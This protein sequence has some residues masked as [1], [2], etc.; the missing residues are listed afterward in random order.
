MSSTMPAVCGSSSLTQAP[1]LAVLRELEKRLH[2]R[3]R[4]LAG[5][6]A[7]EPL[8]HADRCGQFLVVQLLQ[9]GLVIEQIHLRGP[10][11]HEQVN[12]PLGLGREVRLAQDGRAAAI[13]RPERRAEGRIQQRAQRG[14]ADAGGGAA[15][16]MAPR[17]HQLVHVRSMMVL[18]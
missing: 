1:R 13:S 5:G 12:H 11:G 8:A 17:R 15:K 4:A 2:H 9:R 6:H 7:G 16:E 18:S 3:E 10:A 14:G